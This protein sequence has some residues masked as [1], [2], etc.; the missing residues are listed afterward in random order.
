MFV[1]ERV[2]LEKLNETKKENPIDLENQEASFREELLKVKR[3]K[4]NLTA[5]MKEKNDKIETLENE[6]EYSTADKEVLKGMVE[7]NKVALDEKTQELYDQKKENSDIKV[8]L[9]AS[10]SDLFK[11]KLKNQP[12]NQS[13]YECS[14]CSFR[15]PSYKMLKQHIRSEHCRNKA[16]QNDIIS[17]FEEYSCYYCDERISSTSDLE[18]HTTSCPGCIS[19][20][21]EVE[22]PCNVCETNC[23]S[24][25]ELEHH[26]TVYHYEWDLPDEPIFLHE[27]PCDVCDKNCRSQVELEQHIGS[28]HYTF[29]TEADLKSCDFC[30]LKF[31]TLGELRTHIRSIHKEMLP[32]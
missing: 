30:S 20:S 13:L 8:L 3:E 7:K 5:S 2:R 25:V 22:F 4:H 27:F 1:E 11:F 28:Y 17:I 16:T 23:I 29:N 15:L 10:N 31:G 26:I 14:E 19:L 24:M 21:E 32:A 6:A 9:D 18:K 12:E